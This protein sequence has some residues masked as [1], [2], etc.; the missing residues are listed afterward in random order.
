M[1]DGMRARVDL[2][3]CYALRGL[4][5][6][7][8]PTKKWVAQLSRSQHNQAWKGVRFAEFEN[9]TED[10]GIPLWEAVPYALGDSAETL[11]LS[12]SFGDEKKR[13]DLEDACRGLLERAGLSL[14]ALECT[15][16]YIGHGLAFVSITL[17]ID[18]PQLSAFDDKFIA[19]LDDTFN[20]KIWLWLND[21]PFAEFARLGGATKR[22]ARYVTDTYGTSLVLLCSEEEFET[23][24][25]SIVDCGRRYISEDPQACPT[26]ID[27]DIRLCGGKMGDY[28]GVTTSEE[29]ATKMALLWSMGILAYDA[30]TEFNV[31]RKGGLPAIR[32]QLTKDVTPEKLFL[33]LDELAAAERRFVML[34]HMGEVRRMRAKPFDEIVFAPLE[35]KQDLAFH[36]SEAKAEIDSLG[37]L[38]ASRTAERDQLQ[39]RR[40]N[41]ALYL[42]ALIGGL[43][44]TGEF[45]EAAALYVG[46]QADAAQRAA[47]VAQIGWV[48]CGAVLGLFVFRK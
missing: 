37:A 26:N 44:V 18:D 31:V 32:L 30:I 20:E 41:W 14:S 36:L 13:K 8:I 5:H 43:G 42:I 28:F 45:T 9:D 1:G 24:H 16:L 39:K 35:K 34:R 3:Q 17:W 19:D 48:C 38:L 46:G 29:A 27:P 15:R 25:A 11:L 40:Q 2:T 6:G 4:T 33:A 47:I 23:H 12:R 7:N 10:F 22:Q 21:L